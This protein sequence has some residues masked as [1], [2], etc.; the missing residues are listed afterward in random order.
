MTRPSLRLLQPKSQQRDT[1]LLGPRKSSAQLRRDTL[2]QLRSAGGRG[3]GLLQLLAANLTGARLQQ[4]VV[5]GVA[6]QHGV[7][8]LLVWDGK[9]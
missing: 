1:W 6:D 3:D 2:A 9:L 8:E 5:A 7:V 4:Q